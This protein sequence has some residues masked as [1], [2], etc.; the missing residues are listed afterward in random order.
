MIHPSTY[1]IQMPQAGGV[2]VLPMI[3]PPPFRAQGMPAA[4]PLMA[5]E[6]Y[7][8]HC[9]ETY[10][11]NE[12]DIIQVFAERHIGTI[13]YVQMYVTGS[14]E[15]SILVKRGAFIFMRSWA[16]THSVVD[17]RSGLEDGYR[18]VL[19][20]VRHR[21]QNRMRGK[22]CSL[23]VSAVLAPLTERLGASVNV[24]KLIDE[25]IELKRE[26]A[27]QKHLVSSLT[28]PRTDDIDHLLDDLEYLSIIEDATMLGTVPL[29]DEDLH[30]G[31]EDLH[32]G[33]TISASDWELL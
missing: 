7:T 6:A 27:F 16:E 30:L 29:V 25:N 4:V 20:N 1:G 24:Q 33:D 22:S 19:P 26:L 12:D 9:Q 32:L 14:T 23:L 15:N 31:D 28:Q 8:L 11:L 5:G 17:M 10:D 21:F 18:Y 13:S 3:H 2:F